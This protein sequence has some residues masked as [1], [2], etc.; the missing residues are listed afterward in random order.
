MALTPLEKAR[1]KAAAK[2]RDRAY[3]TRVGVMRRRLT[4]AEEAPDLLALKAQGDA[5]RAEEDR[6]FAQRDDHIAFLTRQINTLQAQIKM[7]RAG[8]G[9]SEVS[10][11]RVAAY[12]AFHR[13]LSAARQHI[14]SEFP[15]LEGPA[16]HS[17]SAWKPPAE[18]LAAMDEAR[19]QVRSVTE[20]S[21]TWATNASEDA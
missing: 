2:V 19:K 20:V 17:A 21:A 4:K 6:L 9:I 8:T 15:D 14:K 3:R 1:N 5:F 13:Q 7:L 10:K 18:V 12:D 11:K 16:E